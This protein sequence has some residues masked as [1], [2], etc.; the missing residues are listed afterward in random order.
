MIKSRKSSQ[1]KESKSDLPGSDLDQGMKDE[2]LTKVY[3]FIL[4]FVEE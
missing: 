1:H 2:G 4:F 3:S